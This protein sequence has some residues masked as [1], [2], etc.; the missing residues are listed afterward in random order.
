MLLPNGNTC[1]RIRE[2]PTVSSQED[3]DGGTFLLHP[4]EFPWFIT[5]LHRHSQW[6]LSACRTHKQCPRQ[7]IREQFLFSSLLFTCIGASGLMPSILCFCIKALRDDIASSL[8]QYDSPEA[9]KLCV[10]T[11]RKDTLILYDGRWKHRVMDWL[12]LKGF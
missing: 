12:R 2:A 10:E 11:P 7:H 6:R 8:F 4:P 3:E 9:A 5:S 1:F